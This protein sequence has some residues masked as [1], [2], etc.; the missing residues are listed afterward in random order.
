MSSVEE[1]GSEI[2]R[3]GNIKRPGKKENVSSTQRSGP[4]D[5]LVQ[6]SDKSFSLESVEKSIK[7]LPDTSKARVSQIA[8]IKEQIKKGTYMIDQQ[9]LDT[10]AKKLLE[11]SELGLGLF[12]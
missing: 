10:I 7:E 4:V 2:N 12:N 9:K 6:L 8:A 3:V 11:G 1:L 5:S